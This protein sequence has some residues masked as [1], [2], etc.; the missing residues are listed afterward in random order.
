MEKTIFL[1]IGLHKTGTTSIQYFA[2]TFEEKLLEVGILYPKA[3]RPDKSYG[4][5]QYGQHKLAWYIRQKNGILHNTDWVELRKEIKDTNASIILI[6][7]E[8]FETLDTNQIKEVYEYLKIYDV[9][10]ILYL[11]NPTDF[12]L[13]AY[14]QRV[15]SGKY[16]KPIDVFVD[17]SI[18]RCDYIS[19]IDRWI[20]VFERDRIIIKRFEECAKLGLV[21][22]FFSLI[23]ISAIFE[24]E[25][26][27]DDKK[28]LNVSPPDKDI[29]II[30]F[31]NYCA[32][33]TGL[34]KL[35][36]YL[37]ALVLRRRFLGKLIIV[38]MSPFF[39]KKILLRNNKVLALENEYLAETVQ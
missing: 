22:S 13:S 32:F 2:A 38:L 7:S 39:S 21:N 14:K 12:L 3:G 34:Y 9:K 31:F 6:S 19:L 16:Y 37:R 23:G 27:Q 18:S 26:A 4:S 11:R 17:E 33:K 35:F 36:N 20:R 8:D 5:A 25:K 28:R 24:K 1:H 10:I 30:R 15:K 29:S